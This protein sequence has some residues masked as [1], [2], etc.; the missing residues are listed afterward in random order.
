LVR[1]V[2][3]RSSNYKSEELSGESI[4]AAFSCSASSTE[5]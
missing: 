4:V 5:D 2:P 1:S 3:V